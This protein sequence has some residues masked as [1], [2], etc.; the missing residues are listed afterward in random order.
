MDLEAMVAMCFSCIEDQSL[1]FPSEIQ[2][3][4]GL[5]WVGLAGWVGMQVGGLVSEQV[6]AWVS[7]W[8]AR[9]VGEWFHCLMEWVGGYVSGWV[10]GWARL[11]RSVVVCI[12]SKRRTLV[13]IKHLNIPG[14]RAAAGKAP[15]HS[16]WGSKARHQEW[17]G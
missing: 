13:Q 15:W 12:F 6:G 5:V 3:V 9:W 14:P 10:C 17:G 11:A 8:V 2:W 1:D 4:V 16:L 7:R